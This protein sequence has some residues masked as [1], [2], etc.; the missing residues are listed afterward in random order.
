MR[1]ISRIGTLQ[2][3]RRFVWRG[4]P[5]HRYRVQ[6]SLTRS[7]MTEGAP[8][9]TEHQVRERESAILREARNWGVGLE[10]GGFATD[11]HLLAYLQHHGVPTRL[12]DV[13]SNPMTALWFACQKASAERD[14]KGALFAFDVTDLP[15]YQTV[16]TG[17]SPSWGTIENPLG[18]SLRSALAASARDGAPFLVSPSLPDARMRAQEG[19]FLS[20]AVPPGPA[21]NGVDALPLP[22]SRQPGPAALDA[23]FAPRER[24]RGRPRGLPFC[25]IVIPTNVKARVSPHLEG[26][27]NRS[28]RTLFPDV[29]G[30]AE[31]L[32]L[33]K[34]DLSEPEALPIAYEDVNEGRPSTT[35]STREG[36]P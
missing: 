3:G 26:T 30:F 29:T 2:A 1:A 36:E 35:E 16:G 24:Q 9:P 27:Y 25:V 31:A 15:E 7:L 17:A 5:D 32:R 28:Y 8:M 21:V 20:G 12:L 19:L 11:L 4:V 13:T 10:A 22:V 33:H 6:S 34:L 18:W 23:L 14:A